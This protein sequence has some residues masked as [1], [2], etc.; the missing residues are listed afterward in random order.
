M[1]YYLRVLGKQD[2]EIS[3][4]AI[5]AYLKKSGIEIDIEVESG[6]EERWEIVTVL[7]SN[8]NAIT[9]IERNP[10]DEEGSLGYEELQEFKDDIKDDQ[11]AS[12]VQWL[13][14]F[15]REVKVIYAFQVLDFADDSQGWDIIDEIKTML[16]ELT[17]GIDQAD[18]EGF[19]N[20]EGFHILWQFFDTVEGEWSMAVLDQD[21]NWIKFQM[22]LSNKDHRAAF[23]KGL[24]PEGIKPLAS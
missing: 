6:T 14:Q 2:P 11:P 21:N 18:N 19:S 17:K 7:D 9:Q 22:E 8:G 13:M 15:F 24:V 16:L 4:S 20:E 3:A 1:S 23:K 5:K 12:A 10:S